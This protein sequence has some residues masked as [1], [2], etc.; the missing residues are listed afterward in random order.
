MQSGF[1]LQ[2]PRLTPVVKGLLFSL[3]A[4]FVLQL[5]LATFARFPVEPVLGFSPTM[6]FSG[7]VWQIA[8]YPFLHGG[9]FHLLINCAILYMVG[10]ELERRWGSKKFLTFYAVCAVG[11]A[12]LQS[13]IWLG[14]LVLGYDNFSQ[15]VGS[16]PVVGA[17]GALYGLFMAFGLL[18]GESRVLFMLVVPMKAKHF[19]ALIVGIEL[20]SSI[21]YSNSGVAHAVHLGGLAAGFVLLKLRGPNLDGGGGGGFFR[22][23]T[24]SMDRDE[25]SRRLKLVSKPQS[26]ES[27]AKTKYPITWN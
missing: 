22:K 17:S 11:G 25:V 27:S 6:F 1:V 8:S 26:Q 23:K 7:F 13:L 15:L 2:Q 20:F 10:A 5:S 24:K 3:V 16:T 21:F 12:M 9:L 4:V 18:Y 19:A 14:A